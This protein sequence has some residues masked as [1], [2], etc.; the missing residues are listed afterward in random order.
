[1][2]VLCPR[3]VAFGVLGFIAVA[4]GAA[5]AAR[6]SCDDLTS[7]LSIGR[8][9]EQVAREFGT[10]QARVSA[11]VALEAQE[12]MHAA[13]RELFESRRVDRGLPIP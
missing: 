12:A 2:R 8:S 9:E 1:M 11:C 13:Q 6:P 4:A 10:T 5:Q 7:A 3:R